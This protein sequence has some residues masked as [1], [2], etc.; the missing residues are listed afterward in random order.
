MPTPVEQR[1][2][3]DS[4]DVS[5][6]IAVVDGGKVLVET[7]APWFT[8]EGEQRFRFKSP[9]RLRVPEKMARHLEDGNAAV[10]VKEPKAKPKKKGPAPE[11]KAKVPEET[12]AAEPEE[13]DDDPFDFE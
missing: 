7:V 5:E 3:H 12:K 4:V 1:I 11:N 6:E 9:D 10:R 8:F 13:N 2:L